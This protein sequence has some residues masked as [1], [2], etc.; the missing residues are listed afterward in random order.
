M[1]EQLQGDWLDFHRDSHNAREKGPMSR[2]RIMV[3]L[4]EVCYDF[5]GASRFLLRE[6]FGVTVPS[7]S[8]YWAFTKDYLAQQGLPEAWNWLWTEGVKRGLFRHGNLISGAA[9]G[10]ND[11]AAYGDIVVIT[12]RPRTAGPDTLGWLSWHGLPTYEVHILGPHQK[13]SDVLPYCDLYIDDSMAN[14][15]DLQDNT[16]GKVLCWSRPWN[17]G[18]EGL[19][20]VQNWEECVEWATKLAFNV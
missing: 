6:H 17:A 2:L 1:S 18:A 5:E 3:D 19:T 13:K 4:D 7:P 11:L 20:R 9:K 14:C 8:R 15:F 12:A 10:V 16:T